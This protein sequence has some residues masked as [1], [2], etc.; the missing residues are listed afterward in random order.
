MHVRVLLLVAV[1]VI[2]GQQ[3]LGIQHSGRGAC[4]SR[5]MHAL[6]NDGATINHATDEPGPAANEPRSLN[7]R[8][9]EGLRMD[10]SPQNSGI[11]RSKVLD[12]RLDA[13]ED[14]RLGPIFARAL[15][16][17]KGKFAGAH[18]VLSA[19]ADIPTTSSGGN[20]HAA[21]ADASGTT[22]GA[23]D[24]KALISDKL[25]AT[26]SKLSDSPLSD[27]VHGVEESLRAT[28]DAMNAILTSSPEELEVKLQT[29]LAWLTDAV[30]LDKAMGQEHD[31][32]MNEQQRVLLEKA[33]G[34]LA[35]RKE[36]LDSTKRSRLSS[37]GRT[38]RQSQP[39]NSRQHGKQQK[40]DDL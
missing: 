1:V 6:C 16:G 24:L 32:V 18:R 4:S 29:A 15:Q 25:S 17:S 13:E 27:E 8:S 5:E 12:R 20:A 10:S 33:E 22:L 40:H 26:K 36:Q 35:R 23:S 34:I 21:R 19:M 31:A 38:A 30:A 2:L 7:S 39:Q 28:K 11:K 3:V 9:H 14:T 37:Q